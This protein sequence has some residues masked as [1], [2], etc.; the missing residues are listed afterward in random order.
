M[1]LESLYDSDLSSGDNFLWQG[2]EIEYF[3]KMVLELL[4]DD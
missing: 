4:W 1:V 2:R 3:P